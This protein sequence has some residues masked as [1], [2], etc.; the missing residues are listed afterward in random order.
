MRLDKNR[1]TTAFADWL[2]AEAI[3]THQWQLPQARFYSSLA[4]VMR[5][6]SYCKYCKTILACN[7]CQT[8]QLYRHAKVGSNIRGFCGDL[9]LIRTVINS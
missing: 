7:Y 9:G 5:K 4:V 1:L 8:V 2:Y 3:S 6:I